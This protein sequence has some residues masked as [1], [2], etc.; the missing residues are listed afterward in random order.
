MSLESIISKLFGIFLGGGGGIVFISQV[1]SQRQ[2]TICRNNFPT[3]ATSNIH[4]HFVHYDLHDGLHSRARWCEFIKPTKSGAMNTWWRQHYKVHTSQYILSRC[5]TIAYI[6]GELAEQMALVL[7]ILPIC[8][9]FVAKIWLPN[10]WFSL[11]LL[12]LLCLSF[13][14]F[15]KMSTR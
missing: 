14:A 10:A 3:L 11:L 7:H 8:I 12:L 5:K 15:A 1:S 2:T 6:G 9:H 4:K 13:H